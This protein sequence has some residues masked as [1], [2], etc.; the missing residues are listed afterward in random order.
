MSN[1]QYVFID[2]SRVPGR[3]ALQA[4]IDRLDFDLQLHPELDL[5]KDEGF[6]PCVLEGVA[7]VGFELQPMTADEAADG[8]EDMLALADGRD[9][10]LTFSWR[11]SL[12]DCAAVMVVSCA[13]SQDFGAIASYE[14]DE[15]EPLDAMLEGA[16]SVV[17]DARKEK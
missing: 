15:P 4:S 14:G 10:C 7:D 6:S 17:E 11:G 5:L 12:K 3:A 13:L 16:R 8:D 1:T 2:K 9:H